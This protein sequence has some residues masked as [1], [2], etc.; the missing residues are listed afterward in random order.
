MELNRYSKILHKHPREIVLLKG[1][2]CFWSKCNFCDY[3][4][5]NTK[6]NALISSINKGILHQVTGEFGVLE[7]INSASIFEL[8]ED[9]WALIKEII[10]KKDIKKLFFEVHWQHYKRLQEVRDYFKVDICFKTGVE[11]FNNEFRQNVL[12]KGADFKSYIEVKKY[13][14]SPCIMVG[15]QGQTKEMIR[16]DIRI[17]ENHFKHATVNLF[18]E[19]SRSIKADKKIIE[20]FKQEYD[21]LNDNNK[22]EVL[23]NN[24]DFG[25]G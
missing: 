3:I 10:T 25:V 11:T 6:D 1:R 20:W 2:P 14:D 15:I 8:P 17:I 16:E 7:V 12:N 5:D 24:T 22:I 9:I 4:E 21:Y 23:W 18:I 13:F 19:N